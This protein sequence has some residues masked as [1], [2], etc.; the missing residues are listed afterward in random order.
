M[1]HITSIKVVIRDLTALQR[2]AEGLGMELVRNQSTFKWFGRFVGDSPL[3]EGRTR[4][5]MGKCQHALRVKDNYDA[6]EV[7][8]VFRRD[9]EGWDLHYDSWQ[10]GYGLEKVAGKGCGK[11]LQ[12]YAEE[13]LLDDLVAYSIQGWNAT[14]EV[15]ANGD[16]LLTL[17]SSNGSPGTDP[18]G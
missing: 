15:K 2:A 18:W 7:G 12:A 8:V 9:G 11:L 17:T 14:R 6:Y 3:P 5:E 16:V 1:S 13:A 4:E 10:E